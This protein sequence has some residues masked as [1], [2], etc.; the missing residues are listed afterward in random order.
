MGLWPDSARRQA[1]DFRAGGW[2]FDRSWEA[3]CPAWNR[4]FQSSLDSRHRISGVG[5]RM[6]GR[7]W[8]AGCPAAEALGLLLVQLL[9]GCTGAGCPAVE[10]V[11]VVASMLPS[12]MV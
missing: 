5:R 10:A 3:G 11:S 8:G 6:S 4:P 12:Q 9:G 1:P 7:C 2:T